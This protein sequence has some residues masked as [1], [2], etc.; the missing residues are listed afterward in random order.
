MKYQITLQKQPTNGNFQ[1]VLGPTGSVALVGTA[2]GTASPEESDPTNF[3]RFTDDF[4]L[5]FVRLERVTSMAA[6]G[7]FSLL[8]LFCLFFPH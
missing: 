5:R 6:Q 8:S 4:T 2:L 7:G 3:F 1:P